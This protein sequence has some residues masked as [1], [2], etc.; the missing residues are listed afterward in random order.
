MPRLRSASRFAPGLV[1]RR[2][3]VSRHRGRCVPT[4]RPGC[5]CIRSGFEPSPNPATAT[6]SS[7]TARPAGRSRS[8]P[9][10]TGRWRRMRCGSSRCNALARRSTTRSLPGTTDPPGTSAC[11]RTAVTLECARGP[12]PTR[13]ACI[14]VGGATVSSTSRADGT[15]PA[16]T[17][18]TSSTPGC[19]SPSS[20]QSVS[21]RCATGRRTGRSPRSTNNC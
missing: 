3:S 21:A 15:T 10:R 1:R 6:A 5:G 16:T 2:W 14:P 13:N 19:P 7:P 9:T 18:S 4:R 11:R 17:A 12:A 20:S 8:L